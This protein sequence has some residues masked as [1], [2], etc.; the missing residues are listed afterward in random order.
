MI[1]K[2]SISRKILEYIQAHPDGVTR[3]E[4]IENLEL[5][6]KPQVISSLLGNLRRNSAIEN[7]GGYAVYAR[8]YPID[9]PPIDQFYINL[10][11]DL[12]D[13]LPEVHH[14]VRKTYLATRLQEVFEGES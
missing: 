3:K 10:A 4:I 11:E 2:N 14:R 7:R 8:W 1:H 9:T 5:T 12:L 6:N 13:E